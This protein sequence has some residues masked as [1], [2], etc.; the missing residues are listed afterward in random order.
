M[1]EKKDSNEEGLRA[2]SQGTRKRCV[3]YNNLTLGKGILNRKKKKRE[4][5]EKRRGTRQ[6]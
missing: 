6:E 4:E 2:A 1:R 5:R 3:S